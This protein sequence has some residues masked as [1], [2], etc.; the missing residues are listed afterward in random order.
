[1]SS[2]E[3]SYATFT[4]KI[5]FLQLGSGY[6]QL[7][8]FAIF[9][10]KFFSL[11]RNITLYLTSNLFTII[12]VQLNIIRGC[13]DIFTIITTRYYLQLYV[14]TIFHLNQQIE[15]LTV[16]QIR[17]RLLISKFNRNYSTENV[18]FP[19]RL[20]LKRRQLISK[21]TFFSIATWRNCII[22]G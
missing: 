21:L 13:M 14:Y 2:S 12:R 17:I 4:E 18:E 15:T 11:I 6:E 20:C 3:H 16:E 22:D 19:E 5:I 8:L 10:N 1:M 7:K 9:L